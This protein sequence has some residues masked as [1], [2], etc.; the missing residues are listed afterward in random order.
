M[1][2]AAGE[3]SSRRS[4]S[5]WRRWNK[6]LGLFRDQRIAHSCSETFPRIFIVYIWAHVVRA[7][8]VDEHKIC[9][10]K[11]TARTMDTKQAFVQSNP[12]LSINQILCCRISRDLKWTNTFKSESKPPVPKPLIILNRLRLLATDEFKA[13]VVSKYPKATKRANISCMISRASWTWFSRQASINS[14]RK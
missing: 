1:G 7:R 3:H 8:Y 6:P 12:Q 5:S 10:W 9:I 13:F 11:M 14:E 2:F 4:C